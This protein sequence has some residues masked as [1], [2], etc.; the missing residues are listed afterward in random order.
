[1]SRC[2]NVNFAEAEAFC[3]RSIDQHLGQAQLF[4]GF[5]FQGQTVCG[6]TRTRSG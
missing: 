2:G 5:L 4:L 3:V 6:Q 1:M